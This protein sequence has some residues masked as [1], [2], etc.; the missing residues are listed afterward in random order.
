MVGQGSETSLG[1]LSEVKPQCLAFYLED[2][3]SHGW[4]LESR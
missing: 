3:G 2:M 4:I 1:K